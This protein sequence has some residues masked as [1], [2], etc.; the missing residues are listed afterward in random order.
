MYVKTRNWLTLHKSKKCFWCFPVQFSFSY[1][2]RQIQSVLGLNK[3]IEVRLNVWGRY[4]KDSWQ[5]IIRVCSLTVDLYT[6]ETASLLFK[7]GVSIHFYEKCSVAQWGK[8]KRETDRTI[9]P[10]QA[11]PVLR[12]QW[13]ALFL[14]QET[15]S[16]QSHR[17]IHL[18]R[19]PLSTHYWT[20]YQLLLVVF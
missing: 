19:P 6:V 17:K 12:R 15:R 11:R 7:D 13:L 16:C 1:S 4:A 10:V 18:H 3:H 20:S 5:V 9:F 14:A 8:R 2:V